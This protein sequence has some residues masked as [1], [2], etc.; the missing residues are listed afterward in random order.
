MSRQYGLRHVVAILWDPHRPTD[1]APSAGALDNLIFGEIDSVRDYF[2]ENS[3]GRFTI[4]RA[5]AFG[6]FPA[7]RPSTYWWGPPDTTDSDG[8]GWVNPHVQ[9]RAE[10]I[11]LADPQFDYKDYD[12]NPFDG[13]LRPDELGVLIVI[14]Q[15]IPFGTNRGVVGREFPNPQPLVVDG[16]TI[17]IIAEAY[18]GN[19]P[20]LGLVA[21][22]LTHLFLVICTLPSSILMLQ[23]TIP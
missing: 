11:R 23:D 20:N 9:K 2:L 18:I 19:P 12:K 3:G 21:H 16:V 5:G 13:N 10:A 4:Q 22:E 14:P 1:P 6:W 15:N 8:D 17:G 7:S